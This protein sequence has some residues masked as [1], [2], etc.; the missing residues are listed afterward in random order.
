MGTCCERELEGLCPLVVNAGHGP[1]CLLSDI[2]GF[3]IKIRLIATQ[4]AYDAGD[5]DK[6]LEAQERITSATLALEKAKN[7]KLPSLQE[8]NYAVQ[9]SQQYQQPQ[10]TDRKLAEW[11]ARNTWFGQP[12]RRCLSCS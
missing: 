9:T 6:Q 3:L 11:Q 4:Q 2:S 8:E 10:V 7:F 1:V 5:V 12:S